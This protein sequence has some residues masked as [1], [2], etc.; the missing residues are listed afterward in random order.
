[1][2]FGNARVSGNAMVTGNAMVFGNAEVSCEAR[3]YSNAKVF[4]NAR[5]R[6]SAIARD[7]ARVC[8]NADV[9]GDVHIDDYAIANGSIMLCGRTQLYKSKPVKGMRTFEVTFYYTASQKREVKALNEKNAIYKALL[10]E[11]KYFYPK[12]MDFERAQELDTV[13]EVRND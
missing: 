4:G 6:G 13:V 1:M 5:L 7:Y 2:V 3:V 9:S 11:H 8:G 10:N 12:D